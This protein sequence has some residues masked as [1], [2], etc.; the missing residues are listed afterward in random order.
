MTSIDLTPAG[1]GMS[2]LSNMQAMHLPM[3]SGKSFFVASAMFARFSRA[4]MKHRP[5]AP[6][7]P[8]A[9]PVSFP[10]GQM[11]FAVPTLTL[12]VIQTPAA[13]VNHLAA[14]VGQASLERT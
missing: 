14:A 9:L 11:P 10:R 4:S 3:G 2:Y 6:L 8:G 1:G 13:R 7:R 5:Q 12:G